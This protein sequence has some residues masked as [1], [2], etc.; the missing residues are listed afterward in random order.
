QD[1]NKVNVDKITIAENVVG[2]IK[3]GWTTFEISDDFVWDFSELK[4]TGSLNVRFGALDT[5]TTMPTSG[6]VFV[7]EEGNV[8][9]IN[10][11]GL[12]RTTNTKIELYLEGLAVAPDKDA[13][14]DGYFG[15]TITMDVEEADHFEN[16]AGNR[17][18][19]AGDPAY[20]K[21]GIKAVSDVTIAKFE[22][23]GLSLAFDVSSSKATEAF[24]GDIEI[25]GGQE[26]DDDL[27]VIKFKEN[28]SKSW[29]VQRGIDFTLTDAEGK[30]LGDD[31][32]KFVSFEVTGQTDVPGI[33][34]G[35]GGSLTV[36]EGG[37]GSVDFARDRVTVTGT[38]DI[39]DSKLGEMTIKTV[40][41]AAADFTGDVFL[42]VSGSGTTDNNVEPLKIATI[43][44]PITVETKTTNVAIGY[45]TYNVADITITE[46]K[47]GALKKNKNLELSVREFASYA[48]DYYADDVYFNPLKSDAYQ[49]LEG[50]LKVGTIKTNRNAISIEIK[51]DS[52]T[53]S[54][55][56]LSGLAI[57][58]DHSVPYGSYDILVG[59][60]A[61]VENHDNSNVTT[62][63]KEPRF[64][65]EGI[66][67]IN[68]VRVATPGEELSI[69]K[70]VVVTQ[71]SLAAIVDGKEVTMTAATYIDPA[72][73]RT[74]LPLRAVAELFG[75]NE[76]S[77][78]W[79][80]KNGVATIFVGTKII[81]FSDRT[82]Q[83]TVN[84]QAIEMVDENG[85]SVKATINPENDRIYI[86]MR[87]LGIA[88]G[89]EVLWN[90]T[91]AQAIF[92]PTADQKAALAAPVVE[93]EVTT[94]EGT[95]TEGTTTEG[96]TTEG[97][98]TTTT[99][100]TT[101]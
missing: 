56:S 38:S 3:A 7:N 16:A 66:A 48:T 45:Q 80:M 55:F 57:K 98:T 6:N 26:T 29:F 89:V 101:A 79:D 97:T 52:K 22:D 87:Q 27:A 54:K 9:A 14:K 69:A 71:G 23:Y 10:F 78:N 59:G 86:P 70:N 85:V 50:D 11:A 39:A 82:T 47:K 88:F 77:I 43:T 46:T 20:T 8:L 95:T 31:K 42:N 40:I 75:I 36:D 32:V 63:D 68:Y 53:A 99:P 2:I 92:N 41:S 90:P 84:G 13:K 94:E 21:S 61:W 64:D 28:T 72:T 83:M 37:T 67:F 65:A 96:T 60:P 62:D 49:L 91:T 30:D 18:P 34:K 12:R 93:P 44:A 19:P 58:A 73:N 74:M 4:V 35:S 5:D 81:T 24:S 33:S 51:T 15:T 25:N 100:N 76:Q 1:R 17:V